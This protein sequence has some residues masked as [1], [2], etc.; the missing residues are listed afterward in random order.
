MENL[1]K[2]ITSKEIFYDKGLTLG[3]ALIII[4]LLGISEISLTSQLF[5][6]VYKNSFDWLLI[7]FLGIAIFFFFMGIRLNTSVNTRINNTPV[8]EK[9]QNKET[10][11][12]YETNLSRFNI[13]SKSCFILSIIFGTILGIKLLF[14]ALLSII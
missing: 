5:N 13:L 7:L 9:T 14:N 11:T 3:V 2:T 6:L 4:S 10:F 12:V 1:I 8:N